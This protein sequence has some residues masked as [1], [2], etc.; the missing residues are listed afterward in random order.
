MERNRIRQYLVDAPES[1][2]PTPPAPSSRLGEPELAGLAGSS[3][4]EL[5]AAIH[6][7]LGDSER[8]WMASIYERAFLQAEAQVRRA[9]VDR[10]L[11]S[12][13]AR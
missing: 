1:T 8:Q 4:V 3:F 6:G 7:A 9:C 11:E 5:P 10:L 13:G 12:I 2:P